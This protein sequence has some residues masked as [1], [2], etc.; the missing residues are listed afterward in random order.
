MGRN[1]GTGSLRTA[2]LAGAGLLA[3]LLTAACNDGQSGAGSPAVPTIT[4]PS[5]SATPTTITV[6]PPG[7]ISSAPPA[8]TATPVVSGGAAANSGQCKAASLR[9]GLGGSTAAAGH[10]YQALLFTNTGSASCSI[11]TFPGVSYV[12]GDNGQQVGQ[13]AVR[14]GGMGNWFTLAPGQ[15]ASAIITMTNIGVFD[16]GT[17]Q[18]TS[19]RGLRVYPPNDTSAMFV[20]RPGTGCA[21]NP[22]DPQLRVQTI[23]PGAGQP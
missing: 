12:T 6:P 2:V 20:A 14:D 10:V 9:L 11:G 16:P 13:P 8:S 18:P 1:T 3:V 7:S 17:C 21:G 23:K 5:G 15:T 22:P 4:A 19:V